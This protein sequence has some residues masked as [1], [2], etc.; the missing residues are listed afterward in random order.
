MSNLTEGD[1]QSCDCGAKYLA[2]RGACPKCGKGRESEKPKPKGKR[3]V[4]IHSETATL[5][6]PP[7]ANAL[8]EGMGQARR[9]TDAYVAWLEA[10]KGAV[11]VFTDIEPPVRVMIGVYGGPGWQLSRDLDNVIKPIGDLLVSA[12]ILEDD[13]TKYVRAWA[14]NYYPPAKEEGLEACVRIGLTE[15]R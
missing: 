6:V 3:S 12:G 8:W 5:A 7:S 1:V 15:V 14:V 11:Q 13:T 2:S 4:R 9:K 10:H